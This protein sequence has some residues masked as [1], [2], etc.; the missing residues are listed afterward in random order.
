MYDEIVVPL[1]GSPLAECALPHAVAL[2]RAFDARLRLVQV[3]EKPAGAPWAR[4]I[5]PLE[6]HVWHADARAYLERW[7]LQLAEIGMQ[8]VAYLVEGNAASAI[9]AVAR[10]SG[11]GLIV[12]SSHGQSGLSGWTIGSVVQKVIDG[13]YMPVMIARAGPAAPQQLDAI[14]YRTLMVPLDG[15]RRAECSLPIAATLARARGSRLLLAH[16]A[17]RPEMPRRMPL[18]SEE[19]MLVDRL[20]VCNREAAHRY[21]TDLQGQIVAHVETRLL[22]GSE[23]TGPL[24]ALSDRED[25]DLVVMGA[26]GYT[27][28]AA[29]PYGRTA[30]HFIVYGRR[31]LMIVQ[32]Q[33]SRAS[34]VSM[35]AAARVDD[36]SR[37]YRVINAPSR[38]VMIAR[39]RM[40]GGASP[41]VGR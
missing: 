2:A 3:L 10:Q 25:V 31:P 33:P 24:H 9:L 37:P 7:V 13:A 18:P 1:D 36:D 26:H 16:V 22:E 14:H 30:L 32:D 29:W 4:F 15:S 5:D 34:H 23:A 38:Q 28:A 19:Q 11:S 35:E 6:W 39:R 17:M 21:L 27:G 40:G 20:T 8:A 12:L 41:P